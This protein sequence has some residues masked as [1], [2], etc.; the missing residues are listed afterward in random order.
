MIVKNPL[1][2]NDC[3]LIDFAII[4][5]DKKSTIKSGNFKEAK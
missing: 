2:D 4:R 1:L 3:N 5:A